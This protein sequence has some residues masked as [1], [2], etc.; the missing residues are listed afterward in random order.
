MA[1]FCNDTNEASK[2]FPHDCSAGGSVRASA[3]C[4]LLGSSLATYKR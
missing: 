1:T 4:L 3:A 2:K